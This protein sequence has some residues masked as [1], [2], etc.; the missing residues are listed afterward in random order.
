V[1]CP[2]D[3]DQAKRAPIVLDLVRW[4]T[5]LCEAFSAQKRCAAWGF[6]YESLRAISPT[7]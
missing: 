6:D 7:S 4:A 2:L 1:A 3:L 5:W